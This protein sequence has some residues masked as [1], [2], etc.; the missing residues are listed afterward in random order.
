[1]NNP[2]SLNLDKQ[3]ILD[4]HCD[5]NAYVEEYIQRLK[6]ELQIKIEN[7]RKKREQLVMD[8]SRVRLG[9]LEANAQK[10]EN[11]LNYY[12]QFNDQESKDAVRNLKGALQLADA[13]IDKENEKTRTRLAQIRMDAKLSV[14][15]NLVSLNLVKIV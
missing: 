9:R 13:A 11:A 15:F 3:F 10:Y 6:D 4:F 1:M 8:Q 7:D 5:L 2:S 12:K 14:D